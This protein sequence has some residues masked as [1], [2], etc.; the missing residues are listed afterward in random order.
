MKKLA[1]VL[2]MLLPLLTSGCTIPGTDIEIPFLPGFGPNVQV[3]KHDVIVIDSVSAIPSTTVRSGQITTLRT[4][5]NNLQKPESKPEENIQIKLFNTCELFDVIKEQ[6]FCSMCDK[7]IPAEEGG[8]WVY[9]IKQMYPKSTVVIDWTL[10]ARDVKI[11]TPC[12][13]GILVQYDYFTPTSYKVTFIS[14]TELDRLI[15]QGEQASGVGLE[16]VVGEG[17]VKAYI[18]VPNQP[19]PVGVDQTGVG[20]GSGVMSFWLQNN[21]MGQINMP[22]NKDNV[23]HFLTY[24]DTGCE[25][26]SI[27]MEN[28]Q[29]G[30]CISIGTDETAK[31]TGNQEE[32]AVRPSYDCG[33]TLCSASNTDVGTCLYSKIKNRINFVGSS[34]PKY[35]CEVYPSDRS[36]VKLEKTYQIRAGVKYS[37]VFT[38]EISLTVEPQIRLQ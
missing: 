5:I 22:I 9:N 25:D 34:T 23:V 24:K 29:K 35:S 10:K 26:Q 13:A 21:G 11:Q 32:G 6:S 37:Y 15:S 7:E 20:F 3:Y 14:K 30:I 31:A 33:E 27:D 18:E 4:V 12:K 36:S 17:P 16:G 2:L 38:K 19:I 1:L 8:S 28:N